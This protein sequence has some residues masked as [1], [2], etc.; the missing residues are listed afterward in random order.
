VIWTV[1]PQ[2]GNLLGLLLARRRQVSI[3]EWSVFEQ[4]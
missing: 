1:V 2:T 3:P 4:D